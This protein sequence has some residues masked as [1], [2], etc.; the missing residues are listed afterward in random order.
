MNLYQ[1]K[2]EKLQKELIQIKQTA[3][4][5]FEP[6]HLAI[7]DFVVKQ[8]RSTTF[9]ILDYTI[10]LKVGNEHY[11]FKHLLLR[12]Y[13]EECDGKITALD[14]LKLGNVIKCDT[15]IPS[16]K[17]N[18]KSFIQIKNGEKYTVVLEKNSQDELVFT[19]FSSK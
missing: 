1:Q 9:K 16:K 19:F 7:F 3:K 15:Q 11:G 17:E 2:L 13:G 12:H 4:W 10:T 5:K 18:R 14:I 8:Q 6:H